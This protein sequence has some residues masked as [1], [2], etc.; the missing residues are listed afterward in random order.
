MVWYAPADLPDLQCGVRV[1]DTAGRVRE[2]A[3]LVH[4]K[5]KRLAWVERPVPGKP[6][7]WLLTLEIT[8]WQPLDAKAW[9]WPPGVSPPTPLPDTSVSHETRI[10]SWVESPVSYD[11]SGRVPREMAERRVL[12]AL[13]ADAAAPRQRPSLAKGRPFVA[14]LEN[15]S[16]VSHRL[17]APFVATAA[18][19]ADAETAMAWVARLGSLS[20]DQ[21]KVLREVAAEPGITWARL[22]REA[23]GGRSGKWVRA[24]YDS[25]IDAVTVIANTSR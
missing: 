18:D 10:T 4:P 1:K 13:A 3:R 25:A 16:E 24:L 14:A 17:P 7:R 21:L 9:R 2:V 20:N 15:E 23:F 8:C 5:R 11:P 6:L 19:R 22:G 12:R